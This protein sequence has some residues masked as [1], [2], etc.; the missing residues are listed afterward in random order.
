MSIDTYFF[1][2]Y[3]Q[4]NRYNRV[5]AKQWINEDANRYP[6]IVD[7]NRLRKAPIDIFIPIAG[8]NRPAIGIGSYRLPIDLEPIASWAVESWAGF[9][10]TYHFVIG[11]DQTW[12]QPLP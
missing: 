8:N 6:F 9:K 12:V 3:V 1:D 10:D 7:R 2:Q 11:D 4:V 5:L